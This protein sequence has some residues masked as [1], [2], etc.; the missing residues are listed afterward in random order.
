VRRFWQTLAHRHGQLWNASDDARFYRT[1]A[2]AEI[3]LILRDRGPL[4]E[5]VTAQAAL[6]VGT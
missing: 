3:D 6:A 1:A 5:G 4:A 2:G